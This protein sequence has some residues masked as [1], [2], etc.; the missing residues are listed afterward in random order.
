MSTLSL[1]GTGIIVT[2]VGYLL[3]YYGISVGSEAISA[4]VRDVIEIAGVVGV[5]IGQ[6]RRGDLKYG[7]IRK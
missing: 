7:L 6:I 2:A 3:N 1:T 4:V 5:I